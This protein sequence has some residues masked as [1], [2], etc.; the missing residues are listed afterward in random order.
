MT[1]PGHPESDVD[2]LLARAGLDATVR[3]APADV[4]IRLGRFVLKAA[5]ASATIGK[6]CSFTTN[7]GE[8]PG[9]RAAVVDVDVKARSE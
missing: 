2:A 1:Q 9:G 8:L 5:L 3:G 6:P 7:I 4:L